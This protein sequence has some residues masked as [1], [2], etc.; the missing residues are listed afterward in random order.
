M[1]SPVTLR[2]S[3]GCIVAS[4]GGG[5]AGAIAAGLLDVSTMGEGGAPSIAGFICIRYTEAA[6]AMSS[7]V[8]TA[9]MRQ[10]R[11][12]QEPPTISDQIFAIPVRVRGAAERAASAMSPAS[13]SSTR[14]AG[15]D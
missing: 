2:A 12:D 8:Q 7:T 3:H 13:I 15:A 9:A 4:A 10:R 6:P 5:G 1:A 11:A 14:R